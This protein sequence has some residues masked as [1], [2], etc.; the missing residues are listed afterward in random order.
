MKLNYP[1]YNFSTYV[2]YVVLVLCNDIQVGRGIRRCFD[3]P[4]VVLLLDKMRQELA[5][6][7]RNVFLLQ[8]IEFYSNHLRFLK[9]NSI[10]LTR[11]R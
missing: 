6:E 11:C 5:F 8:S 1:Y 9:F 10:L 3:C 2:H 4:P 7:G